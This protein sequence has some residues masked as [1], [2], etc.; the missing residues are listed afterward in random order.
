MEKFGLICFSNEFLS[1]HEI[2]N[3]NQIS[4]RRRR[5]IGAVSWLNNNNNVYHATE[6][7]NSTNLTNMKLL[8]ENGAISRKQAA[9]PGACVQSAKNT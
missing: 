1:V 9:K 6:V 3:E 2:G 8:Q 4:F 7:S 5:H